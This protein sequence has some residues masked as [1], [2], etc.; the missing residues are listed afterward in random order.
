MGDDFGCHFVTQASG[1]L[2]GKRARI[3]S[4]LSYLGELGDVDFVEKQGMFDFLGIVPGCE[5]R[6]FCVV[7]NESVIGAAHTLIPRCWNCPCYKTR[8]AIDAVFVDYPPNFLPPL[9]LA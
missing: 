7:L 9:G 3:Q 1:K 5:G 4:Q 6:Q 2:F 8:K